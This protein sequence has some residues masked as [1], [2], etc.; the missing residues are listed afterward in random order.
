MLTTRVTRAV[1]PGG[2]SRG[3][4]GERNF[5]EHLM[6]APDGGSG[7][8]AWGRGGRGRWRGELG[9]MRAE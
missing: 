8:P 1:Q 4:G 6:S 5:S 2:D 3:G 9:V 7:C